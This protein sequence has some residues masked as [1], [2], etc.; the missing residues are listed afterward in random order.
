MPS[1]ATVFV[2]QVLAAA[3]GTVEGVSPVLRRP[4]QLW[5]ASLIAPEDSHL[6]HTAQP[7][8]EDPGP[9]HRIEETV[10]LLH[11]VSAD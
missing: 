10:E 5:K 9:C 6:C 2:I 1:E 4:S 7:L 8:T 3:G 11:G